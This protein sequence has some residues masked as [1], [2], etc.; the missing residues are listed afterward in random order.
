MSFRPSGWRS[1][2]ERR[3]CRG[4]RT[5]RLAK[6]GNALD[7]IKSL[8]LQLQGA[9]S[10][11]LLAHL[12]ELK[13][14]KGGASASKEPPAKSSAT[15]TNVTYELLMRPESAKLE[16]GERAARMEKRLEALERAMGATEDNMVS[17]LSL[18]NYS[19]GV[20]LIMCTIH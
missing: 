16:E 14:K 8:T 17:I 5:L 7:K 11:K 20:V 18:G 19:S 6:R 12:D 4:S 3:L 10:A 9:T 13:G 1:P 15:T 2:W